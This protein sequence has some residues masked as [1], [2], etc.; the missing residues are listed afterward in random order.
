MKTLKFREAL[1]KLILNREK[2]NTWRL[3]D[4]KDLS[5][6]D[7]LVF[8]VWENGKEFARAKLTDV[9]E[10]TFGEL[11]DED[12][13]GHEK[14]NSEKDKYDTYSLYYKQEVTKESPVKIIRF[15][16]IN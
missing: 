11:N 15:E 4:D 10:K 12:F 6:G 16:L 9:I 5:V 2:T 13:E 3:F 8:I 7:E 14:F 1:S